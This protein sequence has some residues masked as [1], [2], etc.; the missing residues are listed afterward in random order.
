M[1]LNVP[2]KDTP[3]HIMDTKNCMK[4]LFKQDDESSNEKEK[5]EDEN[6]EDDSQF[7]PQ[8]LIM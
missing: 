2:N 6:P 3:T 5:K 4:Y 8:F 1:R 7:I